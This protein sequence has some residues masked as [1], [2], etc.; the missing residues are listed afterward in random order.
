MTMNADATAGVDVQ[1]DVGATV[2]VFEAITCALWILGAIL[3]L[4]GALLLTVGLA[5]RR[6][7]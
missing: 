4:A 7:A 5:W 6:R 3:A 1:A 2:P